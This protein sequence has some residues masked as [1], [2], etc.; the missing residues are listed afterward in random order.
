[1]R[2]LSSGLFINRKYLGPRLKH[3]NIFEFC[4]LYEEILV[5]S[6]LL[7]ASK[8]ILKKEEGEEELGHQQPQAGDSGGEVLG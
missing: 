3:Q 2:F 8:T 6:V 7:S 5:N 4:C 1:M